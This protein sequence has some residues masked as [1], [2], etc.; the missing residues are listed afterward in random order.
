VTKAF[1]DTA[2]VLRTGRRPEV[3]A[4]L[5]AGLLVFLLY[6]LT[7][8]SWETV[9][10]LLPRGDAS[11]IHDL[12]RAVFAA[13][14]YP[15]RLALGNTNLVFPYS[16]SA[17]VLFRTL[18]V[19]GPAV[20][21][22]TWYLL[23]AAS[24]VAAIRASVA[25]EERSDLAA[26]W[27]L[28]GAIA[29]VVASSPVTWDLRNANSTLIYLG[30]VLT[31]YALMRRSPILAGALVALSISLKLYSG[32]LLLWLMVNGPRRAFYSSVVASAVLWIALPLVCFGIDGTIRI[33]AS[34]LEQVRIVG[35]P[36]IYAQYPDATLGPP[37][38][39]LRRAIMF[40]TG[41]AAGATMTQVYV[42]ALLAIWGATLAWYAWRAFPAGRVAIPSR[43]ALADWTVLLLAP[44]PF[45]PWLE[46]YHAVPLLPGA[47]LCVI[48]A[49]DERSVRRDRLIALAAFI[50]LAAASF[51]PTPFLVRGLRLLA[52][53]LVLTIALGLLRP[54]LQGVMP[55]GAK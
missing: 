45:S 2:A 15:A 19:A 55:R 4:A 20:F 34:W 42:L 33:Y 12:S 52:Q 8:F 51:I 25:Q 37:V 44:L 38:I 41:E 50:G 9:W 21:I 22:A 6:H 31:G 54:R 36:W 49:L 40:L 17:V 16:P 28:I 27:L 3:V 13:A 53:C 24:L 10:P 43:A 5:C 39:T 46:P 35:D 18:T 23:M 32:L 26:N 29:L 1:V 48:L 30:V 11:I 14:D 47:I 7:R